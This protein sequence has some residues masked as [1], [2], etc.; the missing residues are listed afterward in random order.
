MGRGNRGGKSQRGKGQGDR[1]DDGFRVTFTLLDADGK[2]CSEMTL[3]GEQWDRIYA[4]LLRL[5]P[6]GLDELANLHVETMPVGDLTPEKVNHGGKLFLDGIEEVIA[7]CN[8]D[9]EGS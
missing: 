9:G 4:R 6:S 2:V 7:W 3:T 1:V 5:T 8:R